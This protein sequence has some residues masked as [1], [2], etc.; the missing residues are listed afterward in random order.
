MCPESPQ[1]SVNISRVDNAYLVS[2]VGLRPEKHFWL[3]LSNQKNMDEFVWTNTKSVK[4]THWNAEMPG[5]KKLEIPFIGYCINMA[6]S[7]FLF[8]PL[9]NAR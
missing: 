8:F 5:M 4:F 2:L 6:Y 1:T 3:G 9:N 7:H